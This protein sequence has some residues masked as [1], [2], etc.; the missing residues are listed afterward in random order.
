MLLADRVTVPRLAAILAAAVV[1]VGSVA[2]LDWS[3]P[4]D[5]RT[6]L[7]R[8]VGQLIDGE[9][10]TVVSRKAAA[11]LAILTGS[12]LSWSLLVAALA[13]LWLLRPGGLLRSAP[14]RRPGGLT[15]AQLRVLRAGLTAVALSLTVGALANDS[16]VALPATAAALLV[17]LLIWLAAGTPVPHG[18]DADPASG[19]AGGEPGGADPRVNVGVRGSTG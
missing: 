6:H 3:R 14:G 13:A 5:R 10:W 1:V 11:N 18:A 15:G 4:A 9:A 16:G 19:A 17:P 2:V 7:G 12:P 8:F